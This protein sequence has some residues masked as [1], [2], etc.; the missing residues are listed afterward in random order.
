MLCLGLAGNVLR[1]LYI[2]WLTNPWWVL[3]FEFVQGVTHAAVWAA[4]CSYIAHATPPRLRSSAQGV[5]QGLHHGLGRGCGAV[6]GGVAVARWGTTR[7]FAGYGLLCAV[8]LAAFAFV[9]FRDGGGA[10]V[11][12]GGA[13]AEDEARAVAEAGVLAPHGVPSNPL[14]RALSSTRLAD[15]A[16]HDSYGATQVPAP[17]PTSSTSPINCR[18]QANYIFPVADKSE[19][20]VIKSGKTQVCA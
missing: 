9:N 13:E 10:V 7:T 4:C 20:L 12:E 15:L 19:L 2:S 11:G 8:A 3:P 5:L 6:L 18:R 17:D 1:F 16:H 14:P